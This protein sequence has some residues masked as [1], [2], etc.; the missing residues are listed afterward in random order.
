MRLVI[1]TL[2]ALFVLISGAATAQPVFNLTFTPQQPAGPVGSTV[3][4]V[5]TAAE[6]TNIAG[7]QF[8]MYYDPTKL[9]VS[10]VVM[11][12]DP[13]L[14]AWN[15]S[16]PTGNINIAQAGYV[17]FSW[18]DPS[19]FNNNLD[20]N[21]VLCTVRFSVLNA[22]GTPVYVAPT[23]QPLARAFGQGNVTANFTYPTGPAVI[24]GF[25][26][27][28]NNET[29]RPGELICMPVQ[30]NDFNSVVGW[31]YRISW[32]PNVL[33]FSH[34][35]AY[36]LA[37]LN[38]TKF[39]L[40]TNTPGTLQTQWEDE[41]GQGVTLPNGTS[42]FEVCFTANPN[43]G[44][45][46][47]TN[48]SCNGIGMNPP[49]VVAVENTS[50]TNLWS[51]ATSSIPGQVNLQT[52]APVTEETTVFIAD[53]ITV[54]N[55][56]A[57]AVVPI[58]VR[59]FKSLN[60]MQFVVTYDPSKLTWTTGGFT[61]IGLPAN[62]NLAVA[63]IGT[64]NS[65]QLRVTWSTNS[66]SGVTIADNNPVM[67]LTF[68]TAAAM[69]GAVSPINIGNL[70]TVN[71]AIDIFVSERNSACKYKPL[72]QAGFV[73]VGQASQAPTVTLGNQNNVSCF[74]AN[75]GSIDLNVTSSN[76]T[77][78]FTYNW[79]GP[80]IN[81]AN[82]NVQDPTNLTP[83]TY[84][85]TVTGGAGLT[86]VLA[87]PVVITGPTAALSIPTDNLT[88]TQVSCFGG[89]NGAISLTT[90]GGTAPYNYAWSHLQAVATDPEDPTGLGPNSYT[91]TITDSRGCTFV[92]QTFTITAPQQAP[93]VTPG[94]VRNVRCLNE[95]NGSI[96]LNLANTVGNVTASWQRSGLPFTATPNLNPTNLSG[97]SYNVTI[98]DQ[99]GCTAALPQAII[100]SNPTSA[101]A[102]APPVVN[103]P[104]CA[105]SNTGTISIN[106]T[107]GWG[108][109]SCQWS[110]VPGTGGC[111]PTGVAVGV[112]TVTVSDGNG[113]SVVTTAN[114]TAATAPAITNVNKTDVTC[115]NQGNGS[116]SI[117]V[118]AAFTGIAWSDA[119]GAVIGNGLTINNLGGGTY[120][121]VITYGTSGCT[122]IGSAV[123][124]DNPPA[125]TT[126]ATT[127]LETQTTP[128]SIDLTVGGGVSSYTYAWSNGAVTQDLPAVPAGTYTVTITDTRGCQKI[129]SVIV[130]NECLICLAQMSTT[131]ACENDGCITVDVPQG[132][133]SPFI[134]TWQSGSPTSQSQA[135]GVG[136]YNL[137]VCT[138]ASGPVNVTITDANGLQFVFP[139]AIVTARPAVTKS[140][141]TVM[142]DG[143][144]ANG[145]IGLSSTQPLIYEWISGNVPPAF[146]N[147]PV[148]V[149]LDSGMYIVKITNLLPNGCMIFDTFFLARQ[150]PPVQL[151]SPVVNNPNCASTNNGSIS[152][153]V[154]GADGQFVWTWVGSNGYTNSTTVP[155]I[156]G[157][158]PGTY[159]VTVT[160]A[161]VGSVTAGPFA[162]AA[163]SN[164]A[165]T[166]VNE[167]SDYNGFQVAGAAICNG[168]AVAVIDGAV[169]TVNYL[170]SNGITT[171][172]N[173]TLCGGVYTVLATDALGCTSSFSGELT[174]P[175]A[176]VLDANLATTYNGFG[177][178]CFEKCDG[179]ARVRVLGGV[180]PYTVSWPT[181]KNE[182]L[183][184][185]SIFSTEDELCAG[186]YTV[187]I[188]DANNVTSTQTIVLTEPEAIELTFAD[189]EPSSLAA[190]DAEVIPTA[191][192]TVGDVTFSWVSQF[193]TGSGLRA[194][195]LCADEELMFTVVDA[196][197]CVANAAHKAPFP[198][199]DC[200][201]VNPV[202]TPNGDGLNDFLYISCF[203]DVPNTLEVYD[204]WNQA[205][206][207]PFV[208]YQN[209]WDGMR[210]GV[211]LPEGV[212]FF[213]AT[214]VDDQGTSRSIKGHFN[215]L[216]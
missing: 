110:T 102:V 157:L 168:V 7:F 64:G 212:Y 193:T 49:N 147:S 52:N 5:V 146:I 211:A 169:G 29:V 122:T 97:G 38:C 84:T 50:G 78:T 67:S 130:E 26:L 164:L 139:T 66:I 4:V 124:I 62:A 174:A 94:Q 215:L 184:N 92:S 20:P 138:L 74:G 173:S 100:I 2:I 30:V 34:T 148:L 90:A 35:Q 137:N 125:I 208:N 108:N 207:T 115:F 199:E 8:A 77:T 48:V 75:N 107:G 89:S 51:N 120:T 126:S 59:K 28:M 142:P 201:K 105:G 68:G 190:C 129:E 155:T 1:N 88:I 160:S 65:G 55:P 98:T 19:G 153:P 42:I 162:L 104:Q 154:S 106:P 216:H 200:F 111:S 57:S 33:T 177:V 17:K 152:V 32:N 121:P 180:V 210:N 172:T 189:I 21:T 47:S 150:Y 144:A 61:N 14:G 117:S 103:A 197:G 185:S 196:N 118:G 166:N 80:G 133:V 12:T 186:T 191:T 43:P 134:L 25:A 119:S 9:Q 209:Q 60:S 161:A 24:N 187:T 178:S 6:F 58:K 179:A 70:T 123:T 128:G 10:T 163:Q 203:G 140:E 85:V 40:I 15:F 16:P 214:F 204:R 71:P 23:V 143:D 101:F 167:T 158:A 72:T 170:W 87:T 69:P 192:G 86:S 127:T 63:P 11:P 109:P 206:T 194:D 195:G 96:A 114:V 165:V 3:D 213:V 171:A 82:Q 27:I 22:A 113:C 31:Q 46:M 99:N 149:G 53:T 116:I 41:T 132:A 131:P 56:G 151:G 39:N 79:A 112:Y 93:A 36:N 18:N 182:T 73:K 188:T 44:A 81:A 198:R 135:F 37:G 145:S 91:V 205:V 181:G 45:N 159:N 141:T 176:I 183:F 83:G 95:S 202:L 13:P 156:S 54:T 175:T 76:S 136:E